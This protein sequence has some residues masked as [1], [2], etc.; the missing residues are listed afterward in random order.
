[1]RAMRSCSVRFWRYCVAMLPTSG[2]DGLA[3]V[4]SEQT[5]NS[6]WADKNKL[7]LRDFPFIPCATLKIKLLF[8]ILNW[9]IFFTLPSN[10]WSSSRHKLFKFSFSYNFYDSILTTIKLCHPITTLMRITENSER[11]VP[12]I[13]WGRG[14]SSPS[15]YQGKWHLVSWCYSDKCASWMWPKTQTHPFVFTSHQRHFIFISEYCLFF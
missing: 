5:D 3:S 12:L 13:L 6:T 14:S 7:C 15:G 10:S 9:N 2:S 11:H 4:S 8:N 1:M